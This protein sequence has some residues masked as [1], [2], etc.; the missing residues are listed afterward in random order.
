MLIYGYESAAKATAEQN[1]ISVNA[2]EFPTREIVG[3]SVVIYGIDLTPEQHRG[4]ADCVKP[5]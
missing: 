4:L 5:H 2:A 3:R 1:T